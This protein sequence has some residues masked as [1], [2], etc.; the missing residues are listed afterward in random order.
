MDPTEQRLS[1]VDLRAR[2]GLLALERDTVAQSPLADN[3]HYMADLAAEI[4][5]VSAAYVGIVVTEIATL[6][7]DLDGPLGG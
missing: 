2:L 3:A 7:A 6:R 1:P 5:A 4:D